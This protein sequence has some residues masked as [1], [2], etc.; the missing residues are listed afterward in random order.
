[1][2][3]RRLDKR[4]SEGATSARLSV[5][6]GKIA[7]SS[8]GDTAMCIV[9]NANRQPATKP[10]CLRA[11]AIGIRAT[12]GN[13]QP[14]GATSTNSKRGHVY[15]AL[16]PARR[17]HLHAAYD[18]YSCLGVPTCGSRVGCRGL[19]GMILSRHRTIGVKK[20]TRERS[21]VCTAFVP[22]LWQCVRR[23]LQQAARSSEISSTQCRPAHIYASI[24]R[25]CKHSTALLESV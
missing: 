18:S 11:Y 21:I 24:S 13:P 9:H 12:I 14:F 2:L 17:E 8:S 19:P 3:S 23:Y 10:A 1:M 25:S 16:V 22:S 20:L 15:A 6:V 5:A 4:S 7:H